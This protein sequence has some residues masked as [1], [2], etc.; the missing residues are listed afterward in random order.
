MDD[1]KFKL[2]NVWITLTDATPINSCM[3]IVPANLDNGFPERQRLLNAKPA[4]SRQL[5]FQNI[6]ALPATAGS[7]IG[8]NPNL[9]HWGSRSSS[10]ADQSRISFAVY[11]QRGDVEKMHPT[12]SSLLGDMPF[13]YRLYLVEKVWRDRSGDELAGFLGKLTV[14]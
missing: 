5:D 7:V 12:A 1:G 14:D 9:L 11:F 6:R 10:N 4:T 3:Y 2:I 8:W 13:E